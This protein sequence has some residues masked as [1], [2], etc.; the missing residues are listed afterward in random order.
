MYYITNIYA[1]RTLADDI[2]NTTTDVRDV[3]DKLHDIAHESLGP[4]PTRQ[5]PRSHR[6]HPYPP[7]Q[8]PG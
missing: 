2:R 5:H 1:L 7:R 6:S 3:I 4:Y 8:S